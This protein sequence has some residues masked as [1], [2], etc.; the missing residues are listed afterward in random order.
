MKVGMK[1]KEIC[2]I[3]L[4]VKIKNFHGYCD[5][6]N[7]SLIER[8]FKRRFLSYRVMLNVAQLGQRHEILKSEIF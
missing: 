5:K 3:I 4:S 6:N 2:Q 1:I 8:A 7:L